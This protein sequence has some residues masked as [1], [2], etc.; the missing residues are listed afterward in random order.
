MVDITRFD[1]AEDVQ[2]YLRSESSRKDGSVVERMDNIHEV[3]H[4]LQSESSEMDFEEVVAPLIE[5]WRVNNPEEARQVEAVIGGILS[6]L[7]NVARELERAF[8]PIMTAATQWI[9]NNQESIQELA[10]FIEV[11]AADGLAAQWQKR[12]EEE[13]S[14][15]PYDRAARL[16]F[17]LMV[18]RMPYRGERDDR[19]AGITQIYDYEMVAADALRDDRYGEL[20]EDSQSSDVSF[21][22]LQQIVR[23]LRRNKKAIPPE[24][25]EWTLD[26]ADG[27]SVGPQPRRGRKSFTNQVRDEVIAGTV[28]TLVNCGLTATRNEATPPKSACDAVSEALQAYGVQLS[29]HGVAKIWR[30]HK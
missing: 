28:Q 12:Y 9:H 21:Q 6:G 2:D 3:L 11:L 22:A 19:E 23:S 26:V 13:G 14:P 1:S 20:I 27:T 30:S 4:S 15:I 16:A 18:F 10:A 17:G 5:E 29:H 25:Q 8:N 7:A 24:L